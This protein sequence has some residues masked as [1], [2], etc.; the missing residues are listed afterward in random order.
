ME[1]LAPASL[2]LSLSLSPYRDARKGGMRLGREK[3]TMPR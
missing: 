1:E 2:S 3:V